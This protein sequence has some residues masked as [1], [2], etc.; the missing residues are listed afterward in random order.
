MLFANP[1]TFQPKSGEYIRV[2]VPWIQSDSKR[3]PFEWHPFSLYLRDASSAT[4]IDSSNT[5]EEADPRPAQVA[6]QVTDEDDFVSQTRTDLANSL[7]KTA[8]QFRQIVRSGGTKYETTQIFVQP[9]GNWTQAL[10]KTLG[11]NRASRSCWVRGPYTSPFAIAGSFSQI[12]LVASGIGITR[13]QTQDFTSPHATFIVIKTPL[14]FIRI[15]HVCPGCLTSLTYL[16]CPRRASR[17]QLP[18]VFSTSLLDFHAAARLF[19]SSD[20]PRC[21]PSL[22]RFST[23]PVPLSSIT[24]INIAA[25]PCYMPA[26]LTQ[27]T[28]HKSPMF[29][30]QR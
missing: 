27:L 23:M 22:P 15:P 19:G 9:A 7:S 16:T 11:S 3:L 18:S 21:S 10:M 30:C 6:L 12:I 8:E 24:V 14:F 26:F 5:D 13:A 1:K 2:M 25:N 4:A 20:R 17:A 28:H 29:S